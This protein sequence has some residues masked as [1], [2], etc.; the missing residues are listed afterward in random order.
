MLVEQRQQTQAASSEPK[1]DRRR[2]GFTVAGIIGALA[3]I[4][5]LVYGYIA[6]PGWVGVTNKRLRQ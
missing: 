3:V 1:N 4:E 5:V 6:E 2:I